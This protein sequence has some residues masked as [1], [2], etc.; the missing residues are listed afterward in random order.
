MSLLASSRADLR[1]KERTASGLALGVIRDARRRQRARHVALALIPL[2]AAALGWAG[3]LGGRSPAPNTRPAA[4]PHASGNP[5]AASSGAAMLAEEPYMG[6]ACPG[7]PNSIACNRVGLQVRLR[8][9]ALAVSATIGSSTFE[10]HGSPDRR[11]RTVFVG[12]LQP[13]GLFHGALKVHPAKHD[14]WY[15]SSR[16]YPP[17]LAAI[18]LR[19]TEHN[20]R[21]E[22]STVTVTLHAGWG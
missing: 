14:T 7:Q 3:F 18:R 2:L 13:A 10:L 15:G 22:L 19:A 20:G 9:P 11:Q 1:W 17:V 6:V 16:Q 8:H 12:F 5:A 21:I 4:V